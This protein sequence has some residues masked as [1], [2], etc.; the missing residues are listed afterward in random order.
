MVTKICHPHVE[1]K[2]GTRKSTYRAW[3]GI[4]HI[5]EFLWSFLIAQDL[6]YPLSNDIGTQ[7]HNGRVSTMPYRE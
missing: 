6:E 7:S 5:L 3:L 4:A 1:Q 2:G